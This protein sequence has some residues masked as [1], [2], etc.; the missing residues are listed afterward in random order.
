MY[1][2]SVPHQCLPELN[3]DYDTNEV[4]SGS[5]QYQHRSPPSLVSVSETN[6]LSFSFLVS[7]DGILGLLNGSRTGSGSSPIRVSD[8]LG[9]VMTQTYRGFRLC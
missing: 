4:Q 6:S 8:L 3:L 5:R 7:S 2:S 1:P 9:A